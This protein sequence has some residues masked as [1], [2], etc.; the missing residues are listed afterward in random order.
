MWRTRKVRRSSRA[1]ATGGAVCPSLEQPLYAVAVRNGRKIGVAQSTPYVRKKHP[2]NK[3]GVFIFVKF[4]FHNVFHISFF[5]VCKTV[6]NLLKKFNNYFS[7]KQTVLKTAIIRH[8]LT[9]YL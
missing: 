8:F 9:S 4:R 7:K 1:T 2:P 6:N 3:V 5:D